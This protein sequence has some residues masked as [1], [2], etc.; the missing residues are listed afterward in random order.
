MMEGLRRAF[1][2]KRVAVVGERKKRGYMFL[3]SMK[4]FKGEL[5]SIQP[6]EKEW[7]GIKNLGIKNF[8]SLLDAPDEIDYVLIC[9]PRN[10]APLLLEQCIKKR[11]GGVAFFT[12]GFTE[13]G[14][15]EGERLERELVRRAK[16]AG[17]ALIGPNCIGIYNPELGIRNHPLQPWG[18]KGNVGFISQSGTF[19][20]LFSFL[21]P[22]EGIRVSKAVSYGNGFVLDS[23]DYVRFMREDEDTRI[24]GMYIEGAREPRRLFYE[25]RETT[26]KKPVVIWRGGDTE[27]GKRATLS[28][29]ASL[30]SQDVIWETFIRQSGAIRVKSLKELLSVIKAL[31]YIKPFKGNR[32]GLIVTSGGLSVSV[33]DAFSREGFA[34]PSLSESSMERL[35]E[36][37]NIIGGSYKNPL[38][39]ATTLL[40]SEDFVG[41][42][43]RMA[44][45]VG[46]DPLIDILVL[47]ISLLFAHDKWRDEGFRKGFKSMLL[48]VRER[49]KKPMLVILTPFR[50]ESCSEIKN[51]LLSSGICTYLSA[52]DGAYALRRVLDYYIW[53]GDGKA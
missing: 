41:T 51:E 43:E 36:F 26:P 40:P 8:P 50:E 30:A 6:D 7:E 9:V 14:T 11:V 31:L 22:E 45:I 49:I 35:S 25:V 37:F 2:P 33:S 24:I 21:A 16:E 42:L 13:T 23:P 4:T 1:S 12:A 10:V 29:T 18:E 15:E 46:E 19:L 47:E 34:I 32:V 44:V 53:R 5:Y 48:R 20:Q 17:I 3:S 52:E 39:T 28:H 27:G 38:D